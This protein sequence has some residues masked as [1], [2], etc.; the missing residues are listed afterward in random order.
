MTKVDLITGFLGAGK[1]TFLLHYARRLMDRGLHLAILVYDHGAVNVDMPLLQALQGEQCELEMLAGACDPDCHKRRF[2]TKLISLGMRGFDR[3]L[4]E[5]SG[6]FDMDEFFDTLNESPL[7]RWFEPGSVIAVVD[8]RLEETMSREE[9]YFLASQALDAGCILLSR[10]QLAAPGEAERSIRHL[11][12]AAEAISFDAGGVN[13]IRERVLAKDW[14]TLSDEDYTRLAGCGYR[15]GDYVKLITGGRSSFQS[16]SFLDLPLSRQALEEKARTLFADRNFGK[17]LR[18]KG[19]F[20]EAGQWYEMN[21]TPQELKI[22]PVPENR[23]AITVIGM[24]LNENAVSLLLTGKAPEH[25][26]L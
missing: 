15:K 8:A 3:V 24:E 10:V 4:I 11:E 23:G 9:D 7:D 25:H 12:R 1:T 22:A 16:L 2:R 20:S 13:G 26:I 17:I 6:V 18:V 21:A 19:F 14:D 5:P